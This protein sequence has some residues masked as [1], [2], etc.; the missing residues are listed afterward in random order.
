[1]EVLQLG[2][3]VSD[4]QR[5]FSPW[6]RCNSLAEVFQ[7]GGDVLAWR[8]CFS[9][10]EMNQLGGDV[11]AW[12]VCFSLAEVNQLCRGNYVLQR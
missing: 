1:M 8:E 3:G 12:R 2:G 4:L 10:V 5:C 9:L 7:L 11:S 6:L